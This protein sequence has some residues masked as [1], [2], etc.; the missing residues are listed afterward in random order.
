MFKSRRDFEEASE[1][2]SLITGRRPSLMTGMPMKSAKSENPDK[3]GL[4]VI[5]EGLGGGGGC[6][7]GINLF[8]TTRRHRKRSGGGGG[9]GG[10]RKRT[11]GRRGRSGRIRKNTVR[12]YRK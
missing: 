4:T 8:G 5:P 2:E 7:C 3:L 12:R 1:M 6:G 11:N 9:V 10:G